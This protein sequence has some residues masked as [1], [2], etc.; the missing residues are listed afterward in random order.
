MS[1]GGERDNHCDLFIIITKVESRVYRLVTMKR[2]RNF[3][4]EASEN[5]QR[6]CHN[7]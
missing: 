6:P 4:P 7:E 3:Q 2:Q 5:F 1:K